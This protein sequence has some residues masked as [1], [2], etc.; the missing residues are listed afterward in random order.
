MLRP[1]SDSEHSLPN[2]KEKGKFKAFSEGSSFAL[3]GDAVRVGVAIKLQLA[4]RR[5]IGCY[6]RVLGLPIRRRVLEGGCRRYGGEDRDR[7][8]GPPVL[9][10]VADDTAVRIGTAASARRGSSGRVRR[11]VAR[12]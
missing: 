1:I 2:R 9:G 10:A 11:P 5:W 12:G 4:V 6:A 3:S 7:R 8:I